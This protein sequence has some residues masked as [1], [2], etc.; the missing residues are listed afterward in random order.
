V[1]GLSI[2]AINNGVIGHVQYKP[3][4]RCFPIEVEA[5]YVEGF[6]E[7]YGVHV[8]RNMLVN[9][10]H[11]NGDYAANPRFSIGAFSNTGLT[12]EFVYTEYKAIL[13]G[14]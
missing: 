14:P 8:I 11:C 7:N 10:L 13:P 12:L 1:G 5:K 2:N 3:T 6:A 9:M 4:V